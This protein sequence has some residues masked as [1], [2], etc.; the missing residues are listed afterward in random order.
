MSDIKLFRL[1]S[2]KTQELQSNASYL[3][4]PLQRLIESNLD[5]LL[6][7]HFLASEYTFSDGRI[8]TLG[9]DE[10]NCPVIIEYKRSLGENIINQG[11]FYLHWLLDHK[12]EFR[13]L[14]MDKLSDELARTIDWSQPRLLCIANNFTRYDEHAIQQIDHAIELIRYRHFGSDLLLLELLNTPQRRNS[15]P[16]TSSNKALSVHSTDAPQEDAELS[17]DTTA[18]ARTQSGRGP[19]KSFAEILETLQ[20]SL[21]E[22]V[23]SLDDY[24]LS[25][26][27][28]V[29]HNELRLYV[30]YKKL[31]NF[32]TLV[33]Q[34][35][36][37]L[38]YLHL[39]SDT[40][41]HLPNNAFDARLRMHWGTGNLGF[42]IENKNDFDAAKPF[43]QSAYQK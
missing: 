39:D 8:D 37:L 40:F 36:R 32:A 21:R 41:D 4:R 3:E 16:K 22:L 9:L 1:T 15:A 6:G 26:G 23:N 33:L 35:R 13:F 19:D 20:P 30:A 11:L 38:L 31:R 42:T 25:L 2:G 27:D 29:Q 10:N 14:V 7:V 24:M 34:R 12:A 18:R 5:A 17:P 43:I 28:D